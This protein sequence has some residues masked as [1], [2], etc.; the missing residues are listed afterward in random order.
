M[1]ILLLLCYC[2]HRIHHYSIERQPDGTV[3]I[4]EG[5]KFKGPVELV[6]HHERVLDGFLT[7]PSV[8]CER[9]PDQPP[10]AWPGVTMNE[11]ELA[12]LEKADSMG[13]TVSAI[14]TCY[15]NNLYFSPMLFR[16]CGRW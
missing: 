6:L 16:F 11:L 13:L 4:Q 2:I 5:K 14:V 7:K 15:F 10:M 12:L 3:M 9:L 8:A 1:M